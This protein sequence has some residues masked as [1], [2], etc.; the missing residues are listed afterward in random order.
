MTVAADHP[1]AEP[2][3]SPDPADRRGGTEDG[4]RVTARKLDA[5]WLQDEAA[6]EIC[7]ALEADGARLFF[8]GGCVRNELQGLPVRDL[9]LATDAD[10][11]RV[12]RLLDAAGIRHVPT[13]VEHGTVTAV[14]RNRGFE[15]TTF[16]RDVATD[17]RHAEVAFDA[18]LEEDA[19][20]RDFTMNALYAAPDGTLLDPVGEGLA[21]L[22]ARRVRFIGDPDARIAEDRLRILRFFRFHALYGDPWRGIDADGLAACAAAAEGIETLARER[23]GAEMRKLLEAED[24]S[25]ALCAMDASGVLARVLPGADAASVAPLVAMEARLAPVPDW[26]RR[27]TVM[28]VSPEAAL[29]ALRLSRAELRGL[30]AIRAAL[31]EDAPA[32][33]AAYRHGAE[34]ARDAALL[35]AAATGAP[36]SRTLQRD[37]AL[38]ATASF[39]VG[40]QDLIKRGMKPGPALG[41]RLAELEDSWVASDFALTRGALLDG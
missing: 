40:A 24:P 35:R 38:G 7:A 36:P 14:L 17:G 21:D 39:P 16:R 41:R 11:E 9:D 27:L 26:K 13:G 10:P 6:L 3:T 5:T 22:A 28:G 12:Q 19:A 4:P 33:R 2:N 18:S 15:I 25:P 37:I 20:R 8:V 31:E 23:I 34:A 1:D 29:D 30:R 32:A